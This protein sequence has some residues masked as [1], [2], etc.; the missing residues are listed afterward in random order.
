MRSH[1]EAMAPKTLVATLTALCLALP[2]AAFAEDERARWME[3][4]KQFEWEDLDCQDKVNRRW[5]YQYQ[6]ITETEIAECSVTTIETKIQ[7]NKEYAEYLYCK[8]VHLERWVCKLW[9]D[10]ADLA[11]GAMDQLNPIPDLSVESLLGKLGDYLTIARV[12]GAGKDIYDNHQQINKHAKE[13]EHWLSRY[14]DVSK[15]ISQTEQR[16]QTRKTSLL[17]DCPPRQPVTTGSG[18][19]P[20]DPVPPPPDD[21]VPVTDEEWEEVSRLIERLAEFRTEWLKRQPPPPVGK[22]PPEPPPLPPDPTR[23]ATPEQWAEL[24]RLLEEYY[25]R[26]GVYERQHPPQDGTLPA[27]WLPF[28]PPFSQVVDL[29]ISSATGPRQRALLP[30]SQVADL[31]EDESNLII[32]FDPWVPEAP[33]DSADRAPE[34]PAPTKPK[35]PNKGLLIGG[36]AAL[37]GGAV[38]LAGGGG[39]SSTSPSDGGT[40]GPPPSVNLSITPTGR[41]LAGLTSYAFAASGSAST[42]EWNFGDGSTGSGQ[43]TN[44]IFSTG[45]RFTVTLTGRSG[46]QSATATGS[47]D[48]GRPMT[49]SWGGA[50]NN[51]NSILTFTG[52]GP[53][54]SGSY[55][56]QFSEG[57]IAGEISSGAGFVCPCDVLIAIT[58]PDTQF[59]FEG[60]RIG[61]QLIGAFVGTG[62]R[63]ET[64]LNP[65]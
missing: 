65:Q 49:G 31:E 39:S 36:G 40:S 2:V 48:V 55:R 52:A 5:S 37:V 32:L 26:V 20:R 4:E 18:R 21:P 59:R 12:L 11:D 29:E 38:A 43:N 50:F 41:G 54:L 46:S 51:R 47:V 60:Q 23:P 15:N 14:E 63:T 3:Q 34:G 17:D 25:K 1:T 42:W 57:T 62:F 45:N 64:T 24:G 27:P 44:H 19:S 61:D 58:L 9:A 13:A 10:S 53:T 30:V 28:F 6:H 8:Y 7:H 33:E 16:W 35:G 56:D 22:A